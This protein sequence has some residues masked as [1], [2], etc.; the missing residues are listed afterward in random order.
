MPLVCKFIASVL[1]VRKFIQSEE[2][3]SAFTAIYTRVYS[4]RFYD[5]TPDRLSR[6]QCIREP[7]HLKLTLSHNDSLCYLTRRLTV[8]QPCVTRIRAAQ[9]DTPT[10][11]GAKR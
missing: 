5:T 8:E 1:K 11:L 10:K 6:H 7:L 2:G 9:R 4:Y 3:K